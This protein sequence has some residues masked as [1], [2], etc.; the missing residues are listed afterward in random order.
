MGKEYQ[1]DKIA[2]GVF[3]IAI[4][5]I[6]GYVAI[7]SLNSMVCYFVFLFVI[8]LFLM[9]IFLILSAGV[10]FIVDWLKER[11]NPKVKIII[12]IG[13]LIL[14]GIII[15]IPKYYQIYSDI[16]YYLFF[17]IFGIA[18]FLFIINGYNSR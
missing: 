3:L 5:I 17:G 4:S 10:G 12:G 11:R 16:C 8:L 18:G 9:G 15:Y 1:N 2:G 7:I 14:S 13:L 6:L